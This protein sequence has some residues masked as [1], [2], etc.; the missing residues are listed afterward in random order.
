MCQR[1]ILYM[2]S[3]LESNHAWIWDDT[4]IHVKYLSQAWQVYKMQT[5]RHVYMSTWE[6]AVIGLLAYTY[7][8]I[9]VQYRGEPS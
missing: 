5:W 7:L 3:R 6:R 9:Y 1:D 8:H 4:H 2:C